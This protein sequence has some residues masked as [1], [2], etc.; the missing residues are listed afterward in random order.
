MEPGSHSAN[1]MKWK[2]QTSS[3]ILLRQRWDSKLVRGLKFVADIE[4]RIW[5]GTE[6]RKASS[7]CN[8]YL[9]P[10]DLDAHRSLGECL[11]GTRSAHAKFLKQKGVRLVPEE[12][13]LWR[14]KL[15]E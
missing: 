1:E 8:I 13:S 14:L 5:P 10:T 9:R 4:D 11:P 15:S 3:F 6:G 7:G 2:E 12:S